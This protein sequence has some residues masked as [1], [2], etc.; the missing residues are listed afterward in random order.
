MRLV[1]ALVRAFMASFRGAD[2][3]ALAAYTGRM[4]A[5]YALISREGLDLSMNCAVRADVGTGDAI[6]R[7]AGTASDAA[8]RETAPLVLN[9]DLD[10]VQLGRAMHGDPPLPPKAGGPAAARGT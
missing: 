4:E 10:L 5:L 3:G 6:V 8:L 2:P 1:H 9:M 7:A